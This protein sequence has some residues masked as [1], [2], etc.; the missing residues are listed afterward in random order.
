[1]IKEQQKEGQKNRFNS[2]D[3]ILPLFSYRLWTK[4]L[5]FSWKLAGRRQMSFVFARKISHGINQLEQSCNT[6]FSDITI[7]PVPPRPKK[8][9]KKGWDQIDELCNILQ[10]DYHFTVEKCLQRFSVVEQ[11]KLNKE[12]RISGA[13]KGYGLKAQYFSTSPP[14]TVILVDD[15]MTTGVTMSLCAKILK[16]WG[17]KKVYG[18]TLFI[19]D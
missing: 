3:K 2:L 4:K 1:M 18:I 16:R 6:P 9:R 5:L 11:K 14:Q 17:V 13:Q 8:I 7:V 10:K 19:V 12:Q 15:V